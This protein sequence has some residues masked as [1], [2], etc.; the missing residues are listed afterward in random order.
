MLHMPAGLDGN[1]DPIVSADREA[2]LALVSQKIA[3][4]DK[5]R[6]LVG[7]D[8]APGT[9]K[10]TF[11]DELANHLSRLGL[12]VIRST[13]DLFHRPRA[14]RYLLGPTS[15]QGYY[16]DSH[17]LDAIT[18]RLLRPF[19]K[20]SPRVQVAAFDELTDTTSPMF[21][22][23]T[24]GT[25]VLVFDGLFL[26]RPELAEHW[27]LTVHLQAERRREDGWR[28]YLHDDLPEHQ[29]GRQEEIDRRLSRARWPRY[30]EGWQLYVDQVDPLKAATIV[31]DNDELV[32]PIIR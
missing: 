10:S 7:I 4:V 2:V 13:T 16:L 18:E 26:L 14:E 31:I 15:P 29:P 25:A 1:P 23:V 20:G 8:G 12:Q 27:Q 22:D 19:A 3:A 32:A 30:S 28:S 17:D 5:P 21:A 9:G 11:S 24:T 6:I